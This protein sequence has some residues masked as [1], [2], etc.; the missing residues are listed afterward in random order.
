MSKVKVSKLDGI[1]VLAPRGQL[2]GGEETTEL[3]QRIRDLA[4]E[5]NKHLIIDLGEVDFINSWALGVLI[6]GHVNYSKREG[7]IKLANMSKRID[8][9][10]VIT[11]LVRI[12][13]IYETVDEAS[14]SFAQS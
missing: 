7:H 10:L 8:Q 9:L 12:F 3:E 1:V 13:E 4:A 14:A 6:G 11:K 5:G 2:V